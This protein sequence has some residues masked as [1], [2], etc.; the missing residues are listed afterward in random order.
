M[1]SDF[2]KAKDISLETK[3]EVLKRQHNR[4]LA[5]DKYL[6][7]DMADF[8]HF[9]TRGQSGIGYEWNII[10]ITR[11]EHIALH[12]GNKVGRFENKDFDI[13]VQNYLL[14]MYKHWSRDVCKYHKW[15]APKDYGV[16]RRLE[17]W[18]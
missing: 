1:V 9:I 7:L 8:H 18:N 12:S 2:Q 10:A 3:I 14:K 17:Y 6:T 16:E 11:E 15:Y 5:S 4:S 13:Y